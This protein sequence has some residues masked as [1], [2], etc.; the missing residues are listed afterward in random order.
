MP[1]IENAAFQFNGEVAPA[2]TEIPHNETAVFG[3][4]A[5]FVVQG[6]E[7]YRCRFGEFINPH[8]QISECIPGAILHV[9]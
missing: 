9:L 1:D 8:G 2:S 3:C 6:P 4:A 7:L 5:G